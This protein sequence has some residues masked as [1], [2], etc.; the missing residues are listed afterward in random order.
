M[1]LPTALS[2]F[3]IQEHD[4]LYYCYCEES[5]P[6]QVLKDNLIDKNNTFSYQERYNEIILNKLAYNFLIKKTKLI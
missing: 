4:D 5:S 6:K 2:K 3:I 1:N